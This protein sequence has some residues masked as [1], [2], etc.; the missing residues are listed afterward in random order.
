MLKKLFGGVAAL[1]LIAGFFAVNPAAA[2][3]PAYNT[4]GTYTLQFSYNGSQYDHQVTLAQAPD[5]SLTGSGTSG[6]YAYTIDSGS[7][8]G[9]NFTFTAHGYY[10]F[11]TVH[12]KDVPADNFSKRAQDIQ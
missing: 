6:A 2:D 8:S 4:T 11:Q 7:V 10:I 9:S 12:L 1:A 3:V 5:G